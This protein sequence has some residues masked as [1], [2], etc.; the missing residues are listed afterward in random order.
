MRYFPVFPTRYIHLLASALL[1][2]VDVGRGQSCNGDTDYCGM[3]LDVYVWPGTHN[4]GSS[5]AVC[6]VDEN[7]AVTFGRCLYDNH[8]RNFQQQ[9][10]AGIRLLSVDMCVKS[11]TLINCHRNTQV[12]DTEGEAIGTSLAT[13][14]AWLES[15]PEDVVVWR[16]ENDND[17][18]LST[19][20]SE[21]ESLFGGILWTNSD[22]AS[23]EAG[24]NPS[25]GCLHW[26]GVLDSTSDKVNVSAVTLG[27]AIGA[28]ARFVY[29]SR[30]NGG[31]MEN[32][33]TS[34]PRQT[35][36]EVIQQ[37]FLDIANG[38]VS[39]KLDVEPATNAYS[40]LLAWAVWYPDGDVTC[41]RDA[42]E[43]M[44]EACLPSGQ[45]ALSVTATGVDC[46]Y[47]SHL[48]VAHQLLLNRGYRIGGVMVDY[49]QYGDLMATVGRLNAAS[50]RR[51]QNATET[52]ESGVTTTTTP[53]P[54][55]SVASTAAGSSAAPLLLA[56]IA[57]STTLIGATSD[58][59]GP[60][61]AQADEA[62][63]SSDSAP[64]HPFMFGILVAMYAMQ[65]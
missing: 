22:L 28:N 43:P 53:V 15:N 48:E 4:S 55:G 14:R 34:G 54:S 25:L 11:G 13:V 52:C 20:E 33:Y 65:R 42:T 40:S 41:R 31:I 7:V 21:V 3:P 38:L 18:G 44:N 32:S 47:R 8:V 61:P 26:P 36:A 63:S 19:F 27:R 50:L 37:Y 62:A 51:L 58:G 30:Q 45:A 23:Q 2:L 29:V 1:S 17:N 10:D 59:G 64:R 16:V 12:G 57:V 39:G 49:S 60:E 24:P 35:S 9:L 56:S 46:S 6:P 5:Q